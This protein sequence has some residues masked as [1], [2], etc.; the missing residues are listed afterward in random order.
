MDQNNN[1]RNEVTSDTERARELR[2]FD[3]EDIL[4][5]DIPVEPA[6]PAVEKE[7]VPAEPQEEA[8]P[9]EDKGKKKKKK[10]NPLMTDEEYRLSKRR[11]RRYIR[12]RAW[13]ISTGVLTWI[14]D[15]AIAIAILWVIQ[16][17]IAG[18]VK[19]DNTAMEPTITS[20]ETVIY[21]R[22]SYRFAEPGR[23]EVIVFNMGSGTRVHISRVIGLPGDVININEQG[24]IT[25][26]QKPFVTPYSDGTTT[27]IPG[28]TTYPYTVPEDCY[29]VLC[30]NQ[31][32]TMDS[33][34]QSVG[35]VPKENIVGK[36]FFCVW[37]R[38]SWRP[39]VQGLIHYENQ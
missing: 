36:V 15:I 11:K 29:F 27:F 25:V 12:K 14:K 22:F 1:Q 34:F 32:A 7:E 19:V 8:L 39:I 5:D 26:N 9:E 33:R 21:S 13:K 18:Y 20:G 28:Q 17:F 23:G 10:K 4:T 35:A 16:M 31:N 30:D 6:H 24:N 2:E 3:F 38:T 37:P